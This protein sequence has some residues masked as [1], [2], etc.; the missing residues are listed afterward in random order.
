MVSHE[1][2]LC[3][4]P[5]GILPVSTRLRVLSFE[6][7]VAPSA[8]NRA[9]SRILY[10]VP[11]GLAHGCPRLYVRGSRELR[12]FFIKRLRLMPQ[13]SLRI[14]RDKPLNVIPFGQLTAQGFINALKIFFRAL[15]RLLALC[16]DSAASAKSLRV[17]AQFRL[18]LDASRVPPVSSPLEPYSLSR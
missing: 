12:E 3:H 5:Q 9:L 6:I 8:R 11:S 4:N 1:I 10:R 16:C 7:V 17:S 18:Y 2:R 13:C 14:E 15:I